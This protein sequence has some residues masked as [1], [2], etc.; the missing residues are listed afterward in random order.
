MEGAVSAS[1]RHKLIAVVTSLFLTIGSS[2]MSAAL[3]TLKTLILQH[4]Y[5]R[6]QLIDNAK[7]GVMTSASH[8]IN[9]ILPLFSGVFVDTYGPVYM[10]VF[11]SAC[12]TVGVL[13]MAL[14]ASRGNFTMISGGDI[15][16]GI[17]QTSI[18][19]CQLKLYAHWFRGSTAGGPGLL[20]LVTGL[21]IAIGRVFGLMGTVTPMPLSD[22]TG[23]WYWAFW[24]GFMFSMCAL[25]LNLAYVAYDWTLP[26]NMKVAKSA[27][28]KRSMSFWRQGS[29]YCQQLCQN[30]LLI[31][32]AFWILTLLQLL[33]SG[34]VGTYETNSVD[35][36]AQTRS[37]G[38]VNAVKNASY[39]YSMHYAIPI[40]LTPLVGYFFDRVGHRSHVI[41]VSAMLYIVSMALMGFT[42]VHPAVALLFDAFAFTMN[43]VPLISTIPLLVKQQVLIGTAHGLW[44]C[45]NNAGSTI[46]QVAAGALQDRAIEDGKPTSKKYDYVLYFLLA[47]KAVDAMYGLFYHLLDKRYFGRVMVMTER[48]R[49][50]ADP[51]YRGHL[52]ERHALWTA[53]GC[54]VF[55]LM[56]VASY[57][58]FIIYW[59]T[60]TRAKPGQGP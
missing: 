21:D 31:P 41:S 33:Q 58:L 56:M 46:M 20:G 35:M 32:A 28:M 18:H 43:S 22:A 54:I 19:M 55:V 48:Q 24:L 1:W 53:L 15:V 8:L 14:G 29:L 40:V 30:L 12:I 52:L 25:V 6:G 51:E 26:P 44:K 49:I 11:F 59:M 10:S 60:D 34:V 37:D 27:D 7:Y 47:M 13:V 3:T 5:Y 2:Y 16:Q 4:T 45:F 36:M 42:S 17:G 39:K 38:S 57:T 23:H 9:A 50:K